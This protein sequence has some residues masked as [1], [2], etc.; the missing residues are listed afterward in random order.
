M[1]VLPQFVEAIIAHANLT[2]HKIL[3]YKS[4]IK[5]MTYPSDTQRVKRG[6]FDAIRIGF[7]KLFGVSVEDDDAGL[8]S[9]IN[10]IEHG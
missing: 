4:I 9:E 8:E 10:I 1:Q 5:S 6:L 3:Q 2:L 7:N